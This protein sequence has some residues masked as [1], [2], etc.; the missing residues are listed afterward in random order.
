MLCLT[1]WVYIIKDL[2]KSK[3][4]KKEIKANIIENCLLPIGKFYGIYQ[5]DDKK[6]W[7]TIVMKDPECIK[8]TAELNIHDVFGVYSYFEEIQYRNMRSTYP[9]KRH[10][11]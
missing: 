2:F 4:T 3:Q 9:R 1:N 11:R 10:K 6:I 8:K 7:E 5:V